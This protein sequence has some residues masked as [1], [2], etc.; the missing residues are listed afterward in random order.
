VSHAL[1]RILDAANELE[2]RIFV[3][4]DL[5]KFFDTVQVEHACQVARHLVASPEFCRLFAQFYAQGERIFSCAGILAPD[6]IKP[7]KG[8][9]QGCPLSPLIA[10]MLMHIWTLTVTM[11]Q[12]VDAVCYIDDRTFWN[13]SARDPV[14]AL[15]SARQRSAEFDDIFGFSC[16][17]QKCHIASVNPEAAHLAD[18]FNY[19]FPPILSVL[20]V[21]FHVATPK[22]ISLTKVSVAEITLVLNLFHCVAVTFRDRQKLLQSLILPKFTW[23]AGVAGLPEDQLL[24]VRKLMIKAFG[25]RVALHDSPMSIMLELMS[26][27]LD[28]VCATNWAALRAACQFFTKPPRW[29][30]RCS[31]RFRPSSAFD[32]FPLAAQTLQRLGWRF[33][34]PTA[35]I[36]RV[37][38]QGVVRRFCIGWDN[39]NVLRYWLIEEHRRLALATCGRVRQSLHRPILLVLALI[40]PLRKRAGPLSEFRTRCV[41]SPLC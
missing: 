19:P 29:V 26:W 22:S 4:Q 15:R 31:E 21:S 17:H 28:P 3:A 20:G 9:M 12:D 14:Q 37:D 8:I 35:A 38:S 41:A 7:T 36:L 6:W 39:P 1:L 10:C 33:D 32:L 30:D 23:A 34:Q 27:K 18:Q 2:N 11:H 24:L 25:G 13:L 16:R 40:L 5:S